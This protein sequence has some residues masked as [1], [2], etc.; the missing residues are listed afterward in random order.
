M[1]STSCYSTME[2]TIP[3]Q[4][5]VRQCS[6]SISSPTTS[7]YCR[8]GTRMHTSRRH[9]R[10]SPKKER[11]RTPRP[12][13]TGCSPEWHSADSGNG[14][15]AW[16]THNHPVNLQ[17][18]SPILPALH[19]VFPVYKVYRSAWR[20]C[21]PA[22]CTDGCTRPHHVYFL[23]HPSPPPEWKQT[24]QNIP[25]SPDSASGSLRSP[26]SFLPSS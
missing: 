13:T 4:S 15:Y 23:L 19:T 2:N 10:S 18:R 17:S 26:S 11:H 8:S 6:S 20:T 25:L 24:T 14:Q 1:E 7:G 9:T 22:M 16:H 12:S 3:T 5:L 21:F